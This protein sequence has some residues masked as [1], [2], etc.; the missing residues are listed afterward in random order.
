MGAHEIII[1]R[2]LG[3]CRFDIFASQVSQFVV[4]EGAPLWKDC[5]VS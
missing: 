5:L 3:L 4:D 2:L 1:L